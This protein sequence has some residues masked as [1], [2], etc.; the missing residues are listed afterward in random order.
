MY[1]RGVGVRLIKTVMANVLVRVGSVVADPG[2][3]G[4]IW[5]CAEQVVYRKSALQR[6]Q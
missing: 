2:V 4:A 3:S 1:S 6:V 5:P